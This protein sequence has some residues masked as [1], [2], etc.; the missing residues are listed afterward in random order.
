MERRPNLVIIASLLAIAGAFVA[1][2]VAVVGLD[3]EADGLLRK[4]GFSLLTMALFI[5]V[6]G[7]LSMNGQWSWRFL[8]FVQALCAAVPIVGYA[9]KAIDIVSCVLMVILAAFMIVLTSTE[10]AKEWVEADRL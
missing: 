6:F 7:S 8:I 9:F 4:M 5:A 1:L 2:V 10:K 3:V